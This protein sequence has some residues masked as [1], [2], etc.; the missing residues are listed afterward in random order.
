VTASDAASERAA[1]ADEMLLADELLERPR[2]HA[3]GQR[4]ALGRWLEEGFGSGALGS[5]GGRHVRDGSAGQR[6][7][8]ARTYWK[9]PSPVKAT[10]AQPANSRAINEPPINT[11]RRTSRAT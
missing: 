7:P 1:F 8:R 5:L 6:P 10:R 4:L 9:M 2:A 3:G 11:I